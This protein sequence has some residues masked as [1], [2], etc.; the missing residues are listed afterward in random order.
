MNKFGAEGN[1][2]FE[3]E[4]TKTRHPGRSPELTMA[5]SASQ[6]LPSPPQLLPLETTSETVPAKQPAP[7]RGT[8]AGYHAPAAAAVD[9][10]SR[11]PPV[12]SRARERGVRGDG[13]GDTDGFFFLP[14]E[15]MAAVPASFWG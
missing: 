10:T 7:P 13:C 6:S 12:P 14:F 9:K 4:H 11:Q 1:P 3:E 2:N 5:G 15:D 8:S